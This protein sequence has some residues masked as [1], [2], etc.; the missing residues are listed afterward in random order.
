MSADHPL[1]TV[2]P[3]QEGYGESRRW[4]TDVYESQN[5]AENRA[6]ALSK[7]LRSVSLLTPKYSAQDLADLAAFVLQSG[8]ESVYVP[9]W[10]SKMLLTAAPSGTTLTVNSNAA[11]DLAA[12]DYL[13]LINASGDYDVRTVATVP[14]ATTITVTV[15]PTETHASGSIAVPCILARPNADTELAARS[16]NWGWGFATFEEL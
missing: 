15:A 10:Y 8:D 4:E 16:D 7:A 1:L 14:D 12:G 5:G 3:I 11:A 2:A 13:A 6:Q 9:L